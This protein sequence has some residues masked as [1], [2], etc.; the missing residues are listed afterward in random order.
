MHFT[1]DPKP[2]ATLSP[3]EAAA[4]PIHAVSV[5]SKLWVKA[6]APL[7]VDPIETSLYG[8]HPSPNTEQ[9]IGF[10]AS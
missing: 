6:C 5:S 10:A 4:N 8:D 3:K 9:C 1:G 7:A 2:W